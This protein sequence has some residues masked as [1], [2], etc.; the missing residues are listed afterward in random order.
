METKQIIKKQTSEAFGKKV[1]LLGADEHG[2]KYWLE[3]AK[4]D[5]GWYWGFGYVETYTNNN[6]PSRAKDIN[7]HQHIDSSF[8][9]NINSGYI[10][11]IFDCPLLN[12]TT[13]SKEDGWQLS[14]L[15]KTF[16]NLKTAAG[17]FG[18]GSSNLTENPIADVIKDEAFAKKINEV[19]MPAIFQEIYKI[20]EP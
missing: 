7:S 6:Y 2:V 14:E 18:H 16:Y 20:L 13:F 5:C 3:E 9:G 4:W 10:H 17:L 15:F 8:M 19:M 12:K 1:F 11:N